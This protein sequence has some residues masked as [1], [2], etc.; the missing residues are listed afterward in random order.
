[1][2]PEQFNL[3]VGSVAVLLGL[4]LANTILIVTWIVLTVKRIK[5]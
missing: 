4:S 3:I 2:P 5:F 1:M